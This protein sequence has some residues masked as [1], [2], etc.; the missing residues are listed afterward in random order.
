MSPRLAAA[1]LLAG[2]LLC[3]C[4]GERKKQVAVIPKATSHVFWLTVQAGAIAAGQ[5]FGLD[6]VWNG[7][8]Q[9]T[10]FTRQIQIVDSMVARRMDGIVLAATDRKALAAP[11]DRA[12]AAGIPVTV[13]DSGLDSDNYM[14]YVAT[15]NV[16][17]GRIAA[18]A[19][20]GIL[21]GKGK[22]AVVMHVPGSVS[23]M[24]REAGFDEVIAKDFPG[25]QIVQKLYGMSDRSKAM[26]VAE[27]I[28]TAHSDLDAFFASTE[29]ST[30]GTI[31]ALKS[32]GLSGKV[33]LVGFDSNDAMLEA[34]RDG[35]LTAMVI[36]DPFK[37]GFEAVKTIADKLAGKT[38]AKRQDLQGVLVTASNVDDPR[39]AAL[40]EPDLKKYLP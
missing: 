1:S 31:L 28:L 38:P 32:R 17:A 2:I 27:N 24:D 9:E 3:S 7:P 18:R 14:S 35:T 4:G 19:L 26:A 39:I 40:L 23:T 13:F 5:E 36:Q 22:I 12:M 8:T 34:L 37:I 20:G 33:K 25:I 11:V 21:G 15:D 16:E 29:P 6:V 10:D 30:T